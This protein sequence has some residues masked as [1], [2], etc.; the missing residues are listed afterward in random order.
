MPSQA[1]A[2]ELPQAF[3]LVMRSAVS[4]INDVQY[5]RFR[6]HDQAHAVGE[7]LLAAD[8]IDSPEWSRRFDVVPVSA[9]T[10]MN[11][12]AGAGLWYAPIL[13]GMTMSPLSAEASAALVQGRR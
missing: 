9:S 2:Q 12:L 7:L 5:G 8:A 11:W 3:D 6:H 1:A 13:H 10:P 4:P